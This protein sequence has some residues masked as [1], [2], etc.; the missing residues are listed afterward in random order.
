LF[1]E[2]LSAIYVS[3]MLQTPYFKYQ[4]LSKDFTDYVLLHPVVEWYVL[5]PG[6][7]IDLLDVITPST[8]LT[9]LWTFL[10]LISGILAQVLIPIDYVRRFAAWWF[11]DVETRPLN[12]VSKGREYIDHCRRGF[13]K[14]GALDDLNGRS[15]APGKFLKR[16]VNPVSP[17]P[18]LCRALTSSWPRLG[19]AQRRGWPGLIPGSSPGTAKGALFRPIS[20]PGS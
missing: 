2:L 11:R 4:D 8:L 7:S 18:A 20:V 5:K 13:F 3:I 16:P 14:N 12:G 1:F 19:I 9:S 15:G 10:L 17:C 6:S